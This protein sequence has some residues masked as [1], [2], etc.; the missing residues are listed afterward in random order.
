MCGHISGRRA[1][2]GETALMWAAGHADCARLLLDAG[3]DT[4]A[5]D[6]VCECGLCVGG[7]CGGVVVEMDCCERMHTTC[8]YVSVFM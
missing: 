3:A 5:K 4:E 1:Q 2:D 7:I 6:K 8:I